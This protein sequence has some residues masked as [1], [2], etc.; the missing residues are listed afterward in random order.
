[1]GSRKTDGGEN[2][3]ESTGLPHKGRKKT[4]WEDWFTMKKKKDV[5]KKKNLGE[6][7]N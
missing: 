1:V 2:E 4:K 6:P 3:E 7:N 5:G